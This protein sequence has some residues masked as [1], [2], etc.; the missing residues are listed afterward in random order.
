MR[1]GAHD[2]AHLHVEHHVLGTC[3]RLGTDPDERGSLARQGRHDHDG[4]APRS[5]GEPRAA[6][7]ARLADASA[8]RSLRHELVADL[9]DVGGAI[10]SLDDILGE[11]DD[12]RIRSRSS[13]RVSVS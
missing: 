3:C 6:R 12:P 11:A 7:T 4:S 10:S 9:V 8:R 1:R 2:D 5:C 13:T